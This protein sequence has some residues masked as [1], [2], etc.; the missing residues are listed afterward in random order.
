M[1]QHQQLHHG[2][3]TYAPYTKSNT[4]INQPQF[5][6]QPHLFWLCSCGYWSTHSYRFCCNEKCGFSREAIE[7]AHSR[8]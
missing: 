2:R 3:A 4:T 7:K 5:N 8:F 1:H 6:P